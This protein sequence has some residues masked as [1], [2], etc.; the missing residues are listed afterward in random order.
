MLWTTA[1]GDHAAY[2]TLVAVA[3]AGTLGAAQVV[4]LPR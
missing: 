3:P 4:A 2:L 1:L